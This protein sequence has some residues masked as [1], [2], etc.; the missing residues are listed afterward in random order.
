M[1]K[2]PLQ[3][4]ILLLA[5]ATSLHGIAQTVVI[6]PAGDAGALQQRQIEEEKRRRAEERTLPAPADPVTRPAAPAPQRLPSGADVRFTVREIRFSAPSEILGAA[7]LDAI[8]AP[9]RG[10]Q[11]TLNDLQAL[12]DRIN[13]LYKAK[14]VVTALAV[15][16]PQDISQGTVTIQLVE[17]HVGAVNISGNQNTRESFIAARIGLRAGELVDLDKLERALIWFNQINDVRLQADLQPGQQFGLTTLNISAIEPPRNQLLFSLDNLGSLL[18][19]PNRAGATWRN[20]SVFGWRDDMLLSLTAAGGQQSEAFSYGFPINRWG[21][22]LD[23][24]Y[25]SDRTAIRYGSLS[26]LNI[27]GDS[28]ARVASLRQPVYVDNNV[29]LDLTADGKKRD[30]SN[31]I[32]SVFLLRTDTSAATVGADLQRYDDTSTWSLS[33]NGSQVSARAAGVDRNFVITRG[34]A[35]LSREVGSGLS[36]RGSVAW[37]STPDNNLPSSEQ[38]SLGGEG[39]V[40]GYA[41]GIYSGDKGYLIN[42][43]LHH[44]LGNLDLGPASFQATGFF[45]ADHGHVNP[46]RPPNSLLDSGEKL[47]GYGWG[48]DATLN[49]HTTI[50]LVL[51]RAANTV[52]LADYGRNRV[53][54]QITSSIL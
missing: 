29:E 13:A 44:R 9:A 40:R 53:T 6:P 49:Q 42:L 2:T 11:L 23:L 4:A 31:Y 54:L 24:A 17:G 8:V 20:R 14:G 52:P 22:R 36:V 51:G 28:H 47:T 5:S 15:I 48:L 34:A 45:F 37:Q 16:P 25:Y 27:T 1:T 12:A 18:T 7:E 32:D 39:S 19:G 26:S 10:Q 3:L 43:E 21:G 46:Y 30:S 38:F 50:R 35:R 41:P 33:L